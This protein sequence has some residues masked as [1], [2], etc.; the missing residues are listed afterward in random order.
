MEGMF[1]GVAAMVVKDAV[2]Q[3][4]L[5]GRDY[6]RNVRQVYRD[7]DNLKITTDHVRSNCTAED[8]T[9]GLH[10]HF[11]RRA[12]AQ[13]RDAYRTLDR[14]YPRKA[15]LSKLMEYASTPGAEMNLLDIGKEANQ[16]ARGLGDLLSE[17][18]F[19]RMG[20]SKEEGKPKEG[21]K[22]AKPPRSPS[23]P[24]G[25]NDMTRMPIL[26]PSHPAAYDMS[27]YGGQQQPGGILSD[28]F[29][30]PRSLSSG[31][32]D[33]LFDR[34]GLRPSSI[35]S[36]LSSSPSESS[37]GSSSSRSRH[38]H[39]SQSHSHGHGH[40]DK[41][42]RAHHH[43]HTTKKQPTLPQPSSQQHQPF[44]DLIKSSSSSSSRARERELALDNLQYGIDNALRAQASSN[45]NGGAEEEGEEEEAME[46]L[47]HALHQVLRLQR[48]SSSSSP[49]TTTTNQVDQ[50]LYDAVEDLDAAMKGLVA[51]R[52]DRDKK[53]ALKR[54]SRALEVLDAALSRR[55]RYQEERSRGRRR[56][57]E[58][59]GGGG[60]GGRRAR[61]AHQR[62][63][64]PMHAP[65]G[66][67]SSS[68]SGGRR[69]R[70][71]RSSE[72]G[73]ERRRVSM[74]Q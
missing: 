1:W 46:Y 9:T 50:D 10:A 45:A 6:E 54:V 42:K 62:E 33:S 31:D 74:Y 61:S 23:P 35:Y 66:G 26:H 39:Q 64:V 22:N 71:G 12:E 68:S 59:G 56:K 30:S 55:K 14:E 58:S 5:K 27:L 72:D 13:L 53:H 36:P 16:T 69:R 24:A 63:V 18:R 38:R 73:G 25:S 29:G 60:G 21:E 70:E 57:G 32:Q 2:K 40:S 48:K 47:E 19:A 65:G 51:A 11:I 49:T 44:D 4:Y 15:S 52:S 7:V 17:I 20:K 67:G 3:P 34:P 8:L 28:G 43:H 41:K 37:Q